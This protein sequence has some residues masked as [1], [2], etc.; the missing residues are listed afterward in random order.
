M[1]F[2]GQEFSASAPFHFFADHDPELVPQAQSVKWF[3]FFAN[4]IAVVE[5]LCGTGKFL[6]DE[7][8]SAGLNPLLA[9]RAPTGALAFGKRSLRSEPTVH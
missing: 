8:A 7:F 6:C 1:F 2:Q 5:V 3:A 9:R 4:A